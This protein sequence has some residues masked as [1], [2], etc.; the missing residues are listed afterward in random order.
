[1]KYT[2]KKNIFLIILT[3]FFGISIA[4]RCK[5]TLFY[6]RTIIEYGILILFT[7]LSFLTFLN[8]G[9][10]KT[11]IFF[12]LL[13]LLM[14]FF[15]LQNINID[16]Y[17]V[18]VTLG[19]IYYFIIQESPREFYYIKY[20]LMI[21]ALLTSI[22]S[23]IA[24]FNPSFYISNILTIFPESSDLT[25]SFLYRGMNHGLT[26]H[27]SRNAFYISLGIFITFSNILTKK[28]IEKKDIILFMFFVCT[29]LLVAKRGTTLFLIVTIFILLIFKERNLSKKIKKSLKYISLGLLLLL[30]AYFFIPGTSNLFNRIVAMSN[31]EDVSTGRFY[32]YEIAWEMFKNKPMFGNGWG[33]FLIRMT[34]TTFQAVHNDYIQLLA[35]TGLIGTFIFVGF[36]ILTIYYTSKIFKKIYLNK[37]KYMENMENKR[38]MM[39]LTFSLSYQIFFCLYSL[40]GFPHF[41]YEQML[42]Y[43]MVS[44]AGI[45]T[46]KYFP[47]EEKESKNDKSN[48]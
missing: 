23:W 22:V 1:M 33:S 41:S 36:N 8:G 40:T 26:N 48:N 6:V 5:P 15:F 18:I 4:L 42:L 27:Y 9:K 39:V 24:F 34:G 13:I 21:Y 30:I 10:T 37:E 29:M 11:I 38:N 3:I 28:K 43:I 32:L 19:I 20:P 47:L 7:I 31:S 14:P 45:G 2:I 12:E 46:Y 16:K 35:E 17:S 25:Y 44:G